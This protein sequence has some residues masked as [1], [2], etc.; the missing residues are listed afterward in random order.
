MYEE[1]FLFFYMILFV[2][3]NDHR[4]GVAETPTIFGIA[5]RKNCKMFTSQLNT[6]SRYKVKLTNVSPVF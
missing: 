2:K 6:V 4:R 5:P 3:S 1:K